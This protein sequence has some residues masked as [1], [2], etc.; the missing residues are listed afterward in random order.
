LIEAIISVEPELLT[1][2]EDLL[3][4]TPF[5]MFLALGQYDPH[6]TALILSMIHACPDA[7]SMEDR[8]SWTPFNKTCAIDAGLNVLR[9]MLNANPALA[10][11]FS[12]QWVDQA[13][14]GVCEPGALSLDQKQP[15]YG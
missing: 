4:W 15:F 5:H 12:P 9:A 3:G 6:D 2:A 7:V 14:N 11:R 10:S 8:F 1:S 13:R